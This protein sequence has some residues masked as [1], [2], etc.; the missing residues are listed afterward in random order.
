MYTL[1]NAKINIGLYVVERRPDGYHNLQTV[2]YPIP[3][4]DSLE[5]KSLSSKGTNYDFITSGLSIAGNAQDNLVI[6]VYE[7]LAE[8]FDLPAVE[9]YLSKHIPM[10]AGLGGGSS[11]AAFMM[12][13]LNEQFNLQLSD[14]DMEQR[15]AKFGADCPFFV[16]NNAVY[17]EG[18]G[19]E[20]SPLALSLKGYYI[21]LIKPQV[22]VSTAEA[23]SAVSPAYPEHNLIDTLMTQ[24]IENWRELVFND[25][26]KS[27][28]SLYPEI[29]AIKETLYD[30]G[31]LYASMSG[32]GSA[33]Y[34]IFN[35]PVE[36]VSSIFP[37]CFT[38]VN[39]L[40]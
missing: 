37:D 39:Q 4:T 1:P 34:G 12:R 24:P 13:M 35:R 29:S 5:L 14:T 20:F 11:D 6:K 10:G 36:D 18:I 16:R 19:N 2:F 3:L 17:A 7:K 23:Y 40:N 8:E 32:S 31:A 30:M 28:F 27:V 15:L 26:E 33:V 38:F 22:H 25:F 21:V 9:I